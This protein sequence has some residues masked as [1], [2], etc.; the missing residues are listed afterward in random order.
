MPW[1]KKETKR[2]KPKHPGG[3]PKPRLCGS[4]GWPNIFFE[5]GTRKGAWFGGFG[6]CPT[7]LWRHAQKGAS[8]LLVLFAEAFRKKPKM[9]GVSPELEDPYECQTKLLASPTGHGQLVARSEPGILGHVRAHRSRPLMG[10]AQVCPARPQSPGTVACKQEEHP[11][12]LHLACRQLACWALNAKSAG[13]A[14]IPHSHCH[15]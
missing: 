8:F 9:A 2:K 10:Q 13:K 1:R 4:W 7:F 11:L 5:T 15:Y 3:V 6:G 14:S 12:H